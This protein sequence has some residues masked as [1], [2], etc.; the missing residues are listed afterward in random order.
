MGINSPEA[1]FLWWSEDTLVSTL[2]SFSYDY[3]FIAPVD[4]L[5]NGGISDDRYFLSGNSR[6]LRD[7]GLSRTV[8]IL[9]GR[10]S[11]CP[12]DFATYSGGISAVTTLW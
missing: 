9:D 5:E 8:E 12:L 1:C 10:A 11:D 7:V 4:F 3:R 6:S 2:P